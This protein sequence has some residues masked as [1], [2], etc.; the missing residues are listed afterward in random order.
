MLL[1]SAIISNKRGIFVTS[2]EGGY[3]EKYS[4][5]LLIFK[6]VD[7]L[8]EQNYERASTCLRV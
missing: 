1:A 4:S 6:R 7:A 8:W 5:A 2:L 3:H